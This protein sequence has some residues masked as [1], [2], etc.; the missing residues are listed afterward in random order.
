MKAFEEWNIKQDNKDTFSGDVGEIRHRVKERRKA[1]RA[2]LEEV[3]EK[4]N[5]YESDELNM[6]AICDFIHEELEE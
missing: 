6:K 5:S 2:A 1:W 4:I 3:L